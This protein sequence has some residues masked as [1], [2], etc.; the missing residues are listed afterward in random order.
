MWHKSNL[1]ISSG[2]LH[3]IILKQH[4]CK[5]DRRTKAYW[6][7]EAKCDRANRWAAQI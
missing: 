7:D 4:A 1:T 3:H 2:P 5:W 6:F